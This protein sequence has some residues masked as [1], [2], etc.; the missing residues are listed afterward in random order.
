VGHTPTSGAVIPRFDGRVL[1]A[2]VG[3][4]IPYGGRMACVVIEGEKVVAIHRGVPLPIPSA[5]S[6]VLAYLKKAAE[7]D[8]APSPLTAAIRALE[9]STLTQ[10]AVPDDQPSARRPAAKQV[11]QA[12]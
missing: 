3:L 11:L 9:G 7:A 1:L 8:P 2:D 10:L 6:D 4:S 12:P 5:S